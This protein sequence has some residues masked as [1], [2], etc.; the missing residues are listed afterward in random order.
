MAQ[1]NIQSDID[2]F[3]QALKKKQQTGFKTELGPKLLAAIE[4]GSVGPTELG[5]LLQGAT[6]SSSDEILG[7]TR[8]L[9]GGDSAMIA[10]ELNK[11]MGRSYTPADVGIGLE[12]RSI[13]QYR[14]QNPIK[15]LGLETTGSL[16]YGPLGAGRTALM[17]GLQALGTGGVSGFMA[18]EDSLEDR[19][20]SGAT[21]A[22]VSAL[23]QVGLDQVGGRLINPVYSA[24]FQSGS[25]QAT[26]EGKSAARK[27]LIDAIVSDGMSVEE[28]IEFIA[29]NAGRDVALADIGRN[30]QALVDV[31][32]VLPGPGKRT[33]LNFLEQRMKGRNARLGTILQDAFGQR[34]NYYS[35]FQALQAGRASV[36]NKLY[37]QANRVDV[38]VTA[39]LRALL[40]TPAMQQAYDR[41][42]RI[43]RNQGKDSAARFN[44]TPM[45]NITDS[46]GN[47]VTQI[48]T[49]FLHFMKQ[50]LDDVAF[51]RMPQEGIGATEV[52]AIRDIRSSFLK[53]LDGANDMYRRA[54]EIY[55]GDS[56]V[57][58]AMKRGRGFL[59]EDTDELA[60]DIMRMNKSEKEAF[61][62]GALQNLQDQF[63]LSVESANAARNIMKSERRRQ[64]LR[65]A[66]PAGSKGDANFEEFMGNLGRESNMAVTERAGANS[67]TGQRSELIRQFRNQVDSQLNLPQSGM[68]MIMQSLRQNNTEASDQALRA[69]SAELARVLTETNP[70][71]L[72]AIMADLGRGS[73]L[74]SVKRNA[75]D[76]LPMLLPI[77]AR[78]LSGPGVVGSVGGRFGADLSPQQQALMQ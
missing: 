37:G 50:G 33:A 32:G 69:T 9:L 67:M 18:G 27:A 62:L 65:L 30:T 46:S 76:V 75:P 39:E 55:A 4:D 35:D 51:P 43:A 57:M 63:D 26:R 54:R 10:T 14:E 48:Q 7:Y 40:R 58:E 11:Q 47:P 15:A 1:Q 59:R 16:V 8:S 78:G 72:Q 61:R 3:Y 45:G 31:L 49:E 25:K 71:A 56:S 20:V 24:L 52:N 13:D 19:L 64:L 21:G 41:A 77:V 38:P 22:T 68:D 42:I 23:T 29:K 66:F 12:R 36:A 53:Y 34:A 44:I 28:A 60:A 17:R 70:A 2:N 73:F 6:L 5:L 74:D